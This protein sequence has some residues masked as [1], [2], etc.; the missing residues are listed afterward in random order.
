[1]ADL[2]PDVARMQ[3]ARAGA[4]LA[5]TNAQAS[6]DRA[7]SEPVRGQAEVELGEAV[8]ANTHRFIN[9]MLT[10]DALR[11][12][13]REST[14]SAEVAQLLC[15][16]ADLLAKAER[17]VRTGEQPQTWPD[18]RG[19]QEGLAAVLAADPDRAGGPASVAAI[20]EASDRIADSLDTLADELRRQLSEPVPS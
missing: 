1:M 15:R 13:L 18:L 3:K 17:A 8:L 7:R 14:A 6:V 12:V 5:R 20:V 2:S 9:A 16:G 10:V 19:A 4:R 11:P